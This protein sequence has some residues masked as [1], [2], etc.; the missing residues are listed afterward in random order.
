MG[1]LKLVA[2]SWPPEELNQLGMHMYVSGLDVVRILPIM[3][4]S[5]VLSIRSLAL[6]REQALIIHQNQFKPDTIEW[7]E[8]ALLECA[9]I[10]DQMN[11]STVSEGAPPDGDEVP[12]DLARAEEASVEDDPV[13]LGPVIGDND[14]R[15]NVERV[16][17]KP[18][19][20][21]E[22][23]EAMLD[24]ENLGGGFVEGGDIAQAKHQAA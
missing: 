14:D 15:Q 20:S 12:E 16:A 21:L 19:M 1:S 6:R 11:D 24:A 7:G 8:R 13:E 17:K 4:P 22:E 2:H 23:Y 18:R 5:L 10:L 9:K 3:Y